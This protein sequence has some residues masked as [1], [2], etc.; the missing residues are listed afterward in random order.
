MELTFEDVSVSVAASRCQSSPVKS[1]L[2][3]VSG[4]FRKGTMTAIMGPSGAGKTTLLQVLADRQAGNIIATGSICWNGARSK[5]LNK[6]AFVPQTCILLSSLTPVESVYFAC[7]LR[8]P[9]SMTKQQKRERANEVLK[10]LNLIDCSNRQI[11]DGL[12]LGLSGGERRRTGIAVELV[13]S[14]QLLFLDEPSTGLDSI[15]SLRLMEN[16]KVL[17]SNSNGLACT[18]VATIHQPSFKLLQ[19]FDMLM[20]MTQGKM[21]FC[22]SVSQAISFYTGIGLLIPEHIN[23]AEH[24]LDLL[25][26]RTSDDEERVDRIIDAFETSELKLQGSGSERGVDSDQRGL[27]C[28]QSEDM[29]VERPVEAC[30]HPRCR[31][32]IDCSHIRKIAVLTHRSYLTQS[33][34]PLLKIARIIQTVILS[35]LIGATF[36]KIDNDQ[37]GIQNRLG[38]IYFIIITQMFGN[39]M[40]VVLTFAEEREHF[41]LEKSNRVYGAVDYFIAKTLVD[42][43]STAVVCLI[44]SALVYYAIGLAATWLQFFV[45]TVIIVCLA[46]NGQS[47]GLIVG[48][49]VREKRLATILAPCVISPFILF[50]PYAM[51]EGHIPGYL[52]WLKMI[53]P[54]WWSFNAL[55]ANEFVGLKLRC[56]EAQKLLMK[57]PGQTEFSKV[58][59]FV[60]G[61]QVLQ[62]FKIRSEE[63]T[64]WNDI[65]MLVILAMSFRLVA[66]LLLKV[67]AN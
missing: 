6:C 5:V 64:M 1:L 32:G 11:G 48:S 43:P 61:E 45:F 40:N 25:Q 23:P 30:P 53:S 4:I 13:T 14:P 39:A 57:L 47:L 29:S 50:T 44:F 10:R 19:T 26:V 24:F 15:N 54:F 8:L 12:T 33:R 67:L 34:I 46:F 65:G 49:A 3:G 37:D 17:T 35:I 27:G 31:S 60:A 36:F 9:Q 42:I 55:S 28:E 58:C 16:I 66:L 7:C 20:L 21:A 59:G 62:R 52:L 56:T 18:V 38:A 22:G 51:E 41:M 63:N 2:K